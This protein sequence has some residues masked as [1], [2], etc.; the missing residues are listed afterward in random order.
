MA[1]LYIEEFSDLGYNDAPIPQF[2]ALAVQEITI[3]GTSDSKQLSSRTRYVRLTAGA[4]CRFKVGGTAPTAA[5]T[6]ASGSSR[7][8][9]NQVIEIGVQPSHYIAAITAA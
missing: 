7:L 6:A 8:A 5:D 1:V 3:G 2:P 9:A 4:A